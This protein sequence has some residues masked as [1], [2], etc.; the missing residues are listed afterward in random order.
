VTYFFKKQNNKGDMMDMS[1]IGTGYIG[2]VTGAC[3]AEMGHHV[4]FVGRYQKK[5]DLV[6]AGK[7]PFF[8]PGLDQL[9]IK[10]RKKIDTTTNLP[11]AV[12]RSD[13]TFIC[14]GTPPNKEGLS[15]LS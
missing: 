2:S 8:E 4:I 7:S 13:L 15:D 12:Q 6:R 1:I 11:N 5:L 10:S 3:F 9:L 14:V